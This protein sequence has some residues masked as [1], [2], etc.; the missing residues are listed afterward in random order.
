M[1]I[2]LRQ[3]NSLFGV[4]NLLLFYACNLAGRTNVNMGGNDR[5]S[6]CD[7]SMCFCVWVDVFIYTLF[8]LYIS[9][10]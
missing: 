5:R 4:L 2:V 9:K 10:V 3:E 8:V 7:I 6:G 1:F